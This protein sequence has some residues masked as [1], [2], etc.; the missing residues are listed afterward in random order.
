MLAAALATGDYTYRATRG[1]Q[2]VGTSTISVR[3][4]GST[5][6]IDER[7]TTTLVG[8]PS[9]GTAQLSLASDL[10][11]L[12]YK[13]TGDV[14]GDAVQDAASFSG[15]SATV[16]NIQGTSSVLARGNTAHFVVVDFGTFAGFIPL[17]AQMKS[18]G[19]PNVTAIVPAFGQAVAVS[20]GRNTLPRPDGVP[21]H[22]LAIS[23]TG[24]M[25]L[26]IWYDPVTFI[27]DY[28]AIP[29]Q[30]IAIVRQ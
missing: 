6:Q 1:G 26:D 27:P 28:V 20:P 8:A 19:N 30:E 5:T 4:D 3:A 15:A 12:S 10:S 23:F 22:D 18:W 11:P 16:T 24:S 13:A 14:G 9:T 29:S 21:E 7:A 25:P 2:D 17:A